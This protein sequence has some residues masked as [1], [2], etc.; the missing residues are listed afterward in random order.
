MEIFKKV[1]RLLFFIFQLIKN[2]SVFVLEI[3]ERILQDEKQ[4]IWTI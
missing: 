3:M 2:N 1:N 4:A